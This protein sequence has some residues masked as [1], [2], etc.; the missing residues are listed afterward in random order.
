MKR[1]VVFISIPAIFIICIC[2]LNPSPLFR[3]TYLK[4][5]CSAQTLWMYKKLYTDTSDFTLAFFGS[6]HTLQAINDSLLPKSL[7]FGYCRFGRDI[8]YAL[9]KN[10]LERKKIKIAFFE[11]TETEPSYSHPDYPFISGSYDVFVPS[12]IYNQACLTN[13]YDAF[14][15]RL[16]YLRSRLFNQNESFANELQKSFGYIGQSAKADSAYLQ[17]QKREKLKDLNNYD[18]ESPQRKVELSFSRYY[19]QKIKSLADKNDCK[20]YFIYLPAFGN[21][22]GNSLDSAFYKA[23]FKTYVPPD[24]IL[25]NTL[26]WLDEAHLNDEGSAKINQWLKTTLSQ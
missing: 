11:I 20:V 6:S 4:Q 17:E 14:L 7:N 1:P 21:T 24:T 26:N 3:Y 9:F 19:L 22:A 8:Q 12:M 10:V 23:Y 15:F 13:R 2:A 25:N 16:A 18:P 5:N